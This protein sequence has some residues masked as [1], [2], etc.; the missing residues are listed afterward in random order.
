MSL[1][2]PFTGA[3]PGSKLSCVGLWYPAG[4]GSRDGPEPRCRLRRLEPETGSQPRIPF[5]RTYEAGNTGVGRIYSL[6]PRLLGS[7]GT[8]LNESEEIKS[9]CLGCER[10]PHPFNGNP[11][12]EARFPLFESNMEADTPGRMVM[13]GVGVHRQGGMLR[14]KRGCLRVKKP[15]TIRADRKPLMTLSIQWSRE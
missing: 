14:I 11:P 2:S 6:L 15:T 1:G 3:G 10:D 5:R 12:R 8:M 7:C 13:K 4:V 9:S